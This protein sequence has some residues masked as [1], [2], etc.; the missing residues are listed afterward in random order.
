MEAN[1]LLFPKSLCSRVGSLFGQ[2]VSALYCAL[3]CFS[4]V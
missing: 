1:I 3:C 2:E 4:H